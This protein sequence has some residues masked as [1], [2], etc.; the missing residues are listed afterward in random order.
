MVDNPFYQNNGVMV[1]SNCMT[2][3]IDETMEKAFRIQ[4]KDF[5]K[6]K[7]CQ[8]GPFKG[9]PVNMDNPDD[10]GKYKPEE[11]MAAFGAVTADI[12]NRKGIKFGDLTQYSEIEV[13]NL[14][15]YKELL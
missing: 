13:L 10:Y 1:P 2:M 15:H 8:L 5:P 14:E 12:E 7:L 3:N 4:M 9:N 11:M 6:E